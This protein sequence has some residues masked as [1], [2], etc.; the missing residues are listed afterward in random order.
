MKKLILLLA[1]KQ[2]RRYD[3]ITTKLHRSKDAGYLN[4]LSSKG[5]VEAE[6]SLTKP[7]VIKQ[8]AH[9]GT[10]SVLESRLDTYLFSQV[11]C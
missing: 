11:S 8:S 9:S 10:V 3:H 2:Y 5:S 6:L 1:H 7:G 4:T